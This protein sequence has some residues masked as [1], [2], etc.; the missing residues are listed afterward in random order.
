AGALFVACP[1]IM[2]S[3]LR[4]GHFE[5]N[6]Y[7]SH[8]VI[9]NSLILF[10]AGIY[11]LAV[12]VFA[13]AVKWMGGNTSFT[14]KAFILL[15]G[16]VLLT[17]LLVSDRARLYTKR[18]VSRNFQRPMY[19]YRTVWRRFT[20]CT[21]SRMDQIE[22]CRATVSLVAEIF[23]VLSVT[24]WLVDEKKANLVFGASTS[25]SD[26]KGTELQPSSAAA[27]EVLLALQNHPEPVDI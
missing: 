3:L 22:L 11:L 17:V 12:G 13:N 23:Q 26:A 27:S 6:V 4:A 25:L 24:V 16:L 21:A 18:F 9:H 2:R 14:F 10:L 8:S 20:E 1:L 15:V 5:V 19:D 7:P